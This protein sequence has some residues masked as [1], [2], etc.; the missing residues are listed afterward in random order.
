MTARIKLIALC[1]MAMLGCGVVLG[2]TAID[3][4]D[5]KGEAGRIAVRSKGRRLPG[6]AEVRVSRT[7]SE[8]TKRRLSQG[9]QSLRRR[10]ANGARL[11]GAA[12]VE[13]DASVLA[14]YDISINSDGKKWQPAAGEPVRVTVDLDEPVAVTAAASLGV[15]HLSDDG[16]VE[17]LP[18]SRYGFTYNAAK[19]AITAFWFDAT[20]FSVYAIVEGA[21]GRRLYGFY[22]LDCDDATYVPRY[23]T[24]LEGNRSYRQIVKSGEKLTQPEALPS[25]AGRTFMGW[26]LYDAAK[27]NTEGF[28][29]NGYATTP[30]DFDEP[31]EFDTPGTEEFQLRGVFAHNAHVIFHEQPAGK[32]WP[33]TA[34]R[35]GELTQNASTG[36][37]E[38]SVKID[39]MVVT[40][41]DSND[42]GEHSNATPKMIFR[43]WSLEPVIPGEL[44]TTNGTPV[45]IESSP[46]VVTLD[47]ISSTTLGPT[48]LYPVF[49]NI[50]WIT[51]KAAETGQGATYIPPKYFYQ[52]EGTN[53]FPRPVRTGYVFD[54]WWTGTN[55]GFRVSTADGALVTTDLPTTAE[56]AAAE[57][58]WG[59]YVKDGKLMLA[60]DVMLYG[61]WVKGNA[62]YTVVVFR[63]SLND[64]KDT[65]NK[66]YDFA[67]SVTNSAQTESS[68]SVDNIFKQLETQ[69]ASSINQGRE[70]AITT[71]D[72]Y[73]FYYST[74][75][76]AQTVKGN[77][78][79]VLR[80]YYDRYT[81][82]YKFNSYGE[83][84]YTPSTSTSSGNYY[85]TDDGVTFTQQYL[86]YNNGRWYK[87]RSGRQG[88]YSYSNEYTGTRYTREQATLMTGLYGQPL[89][90]YGYEWPIER[91]WGVVNGNTTM[92]YLE[93]FNYIT[94]TDT[95]A[96]T[97]STAFN[98]NGTSGT[99]PIWHV[100]QRLDG[101]YSI[102]YD[103]TVVKT[104]ADGGNG[105][106]FTDKF[107]GFTV[108]GYS[109]NTFTETPQKSK[110][111]GQSTDSGD[112]S[113]DILYVYHQRR[114]YTLTL[115]DSYNLNVYSVQEVY[116]GAPLGDYMPTAKP[117]PTEQSLQAGYSFSGWYSDQATSTAF[118]SARTMP[119]NNLIAY[120]GWGT[121]WYLIQ[122]DP[123]GGELAPGQSNWF[124]EPYNGDPIEE[125]ATT[126]R[127]YTEAYDGTWFYAK[128]D[129]AFYGLTDEWDDIEDNISDRGVYYTQDQSDPAIVDANKRYTGPV[130][131][132]YR[133][134]GWYE[135]HEDGSE[136]LYAFGQ[137]VQHNTLLRL[138]WKHIGTYRLV[139][140]AGS[141]TMSN[142]DENETETFMLLD[143]SVYA[144]SSEVLVT[145]TADAPAGY[146][147]V[148]WKI[149][150]ADDTLYRPGQT[151][152]FNSGYTTTVPGADG[153]TVRQLVL[154]AVYE[155]VTTVSLR[156]D[157][158]GGTVSGGGENAFAL[159]YENAPV[160]LTN[161]S[162]NAVTVYGMRNNA[163]GT[164]GDGSGFSCTVDGE[165]L[166]FLGWNTAPDGTGTHFDP[167]ALIG[168]DVD[169]TVD[170]NGVNTLYAEWGVK[171]YFNINNPDGIW[172]E[173]AWPE[174]YI[175]DEE[176]QMFYQ[177]VVLNGYA[178]D[179][180]VPDGI[181][182]LA[183]DHHCNAHAVCVLVGPHRRCGACRGCNSGRA[184]RQG[185]VACRAIHSNERRHRQVL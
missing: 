180:E 142:G 164:V 43:G 117:T 34:V 53:S 159:D 55:T 32:D 54:G 133:Y 86:Y 112:S 136:E 81:V 1:A 38:T 40:Y 25:P 20:G 4:L 46:L 8:N 58:A 121:E 175:W 156:F 118:D 33:I 89:S 171:V 24:T 90:K 74:C 67:F 30:F 17:E 76:D 103:D 84:V 108:C 145:R 167:G 15:A 173:T 109:K 183:A 31:I 166:Q 5:R 174:N 22:T 134:A 144:D 29:A 21:P 114:K 59:G 106:N 42:E 10:P 96:H 170:E 39:D 110:V 143:S 18:A 181:R 12:P 82:T 73:G 2:A 52:D 135:V 102:D 61:R 132:V 37:W 23:F 63:Q 176:K 75:D 85:I 178:S 9:I 92:T 137:P 93:T 140:H 129:R 48:H 47:S 99:T 131:S 111:A 70:E 79:T 119:R 152:K 60:K 28:D 66:T 179:P 146:Y 154:D 101:T 68:V 44:L 78:T 49:V 11:Q 123:N 115:C 26:F 95:T 94:G 88:N 182:L 19:T 3:R 126:T 104:M 125:Y 185:R 169:G 69:V 77:G 130:Q 6:N 113:F 91:K 105:F 150:H 116:Y 149:R 64:D 153:T 160:A 35:R 161:V 80:V 87:N 128:K 177:M 97:M 71:D 83:Y 157:A 139:Y 13:K 41:D 50:N 141:G 62:K 148:G 163:Y 124:W 27:A 127:S 107:E 155:K 162:G 16:A 56:A 138:H 172:N 100:L 7:R 120:A 151:F 184:Y 51:Y 98:N 36:K 72:F 57:G 165:Q 147:F 14:M 122:I 45:Q 168:L 65:V 158:N